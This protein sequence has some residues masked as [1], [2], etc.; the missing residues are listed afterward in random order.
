M[1]IIL[2]ILGY[3][4]VRGFGSHDEYLAC[5]YTSHGLAVSAESQETTEDH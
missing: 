3:L 5:R 1:V 4:V 2:E